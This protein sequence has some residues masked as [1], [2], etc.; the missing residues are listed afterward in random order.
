MCNF[1]QNLMMQPREVISLSEIPV[2][3]FEYWSK[4]IM[5]QVLFSICYF[6]VYLGLTFFLFSYYGVMEQ[7]HDLSAY[8]NTDQVLAREKYMEIIASENFR[9]VTL[10][11]VVITALLFPLNLGLFNIYRKMDKAEEISVGD[12]FVGFEGSSFFK[13]IGYALFWGGI[14]YIS[15]MTLFLA[16]VWVLITL[17]VGPLMFFNNL[18][19]QESLKLSFQAVGKNIVGCLMALLLAVFGSYIGA[20]LCGVGILL[21]FPFWNAVLYAYYQKIFPDS[22]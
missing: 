10:W 7:I 14:Y 22:H 2:K 13:Y 4:T 20:A 21:T 17:F 12:L 18:N 5:F 11:I 16:P 15:K 8:F 1:A 6:A 3:A 19:I 9:Y